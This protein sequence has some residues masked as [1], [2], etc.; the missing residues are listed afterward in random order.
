MD[1]VGEENIFGNINDSLD[2]A[3]IILGLAAMGRPKDFKS[4]VKREMNQ[5]KK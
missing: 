3:R 5:T 2:R 4:E 1:E